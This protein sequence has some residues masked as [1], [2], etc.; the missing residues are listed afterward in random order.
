MQKA[1][2]FSLHF[3]THTRE[4]KEKKENSS[5]YLF[6]HTHTHTTKNINYTKA[7]SLQ[8]RASLKKPQNGVQQSTQRILKTPQTLLKTQ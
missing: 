1:S 8:Q 6:Q 4:K 3:Q 5:L 7:H 2:V